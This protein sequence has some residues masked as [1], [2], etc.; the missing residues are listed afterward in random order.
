LLDANP[1]SSKEKFF[2]DY[3]NSLCSQELIHTIITITAKLTGS[4]CTVDHASLDGND[5]LNTQI[6][7]LLSSS[8]LEVDLIGDSPSIDQFRKSCILA[9][10][11]FHQFPGNQSWMRIGRLTRL[12][13]RV[14]LDR[15]ENLRDLYSEW[16]ILS[17]EEIREWRA[18]W[19][20]IY[21]L[22]S[23]SNISSG[24]PFL[25]DDHFIKTSLVLDSSSTTTENTA[26]ELFLPSEASRLWEI[27]PTIVSSPETCLGNVHIVAIAVTRQ[28]GMALRLHTFRSQ[29]EILQHLVG[30][31]RLLPT[32]RL[33][34]PSGWFNP[35]RNALLNESTRG[36]HL[37]LNTVL[38]LLM[39]KL[40][41]SVIG[42]SRCKEDEWLSRWQKVIETCQD[43]ASTAAEWDSSFCLIVD[44]AVCYVVFAALIFLDIHRKSSAFSVS[45]NQSIESDQ[46]ILRLYLEQFARLW[47]MPR[48]LSSMSSMQ[49]IIAPT[50]TPP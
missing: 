28:A 34:L 25:I 3:Q 5:A 33:A 14:G 21:R 29:D 2:E 30:L 35:R 47:T 12:A 37:R 24:T 27:L 18:I 11:E 4:S 10:Y 41:F 42:C 44:P 15:L 40:L 22:D 39:S 46:T 31:E 26:K 7:Q 32:L 45:E 6:D 8:M 36:H 38:V 1:I 23:Y 50:L 13:Y 48:L 17:Y 49:E 43:I 19:W 9:F 16:K 20:F